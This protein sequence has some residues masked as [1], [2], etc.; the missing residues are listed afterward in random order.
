[1]TTWIEHPEGGR[2][3]GPRGVAR[4]WFEVLTRPQRFFRNGVSPGDQAPGLVF[5]VVVAV[6]YTTVLFAFV[7]A[8]IPELAGG[9]ALSA[10]VG[11]AAVALL[12]A[13]AVLHI[14][15][16]LQ[17]V[18]LIATV[19]ENRGGISETVQVIAYASAPCVVAGIPSPELRIV[20][21]GYG[22]VLMF[23]GLSEVH[24][25]SIP[26][27]AVAGAVPATFLFGYV[28][29]GAT[30]FITIVRTLGVI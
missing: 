14:T 1:M 12:L 20:C 18:F 15:A 28:F 19:W 16:A 6:A 22:A 2:E 3:R 10:F 30:A 11:L 13:P 9:Q 27:A 24:D 7:P 17:T 29:G 25:V 5:A 26:H 23:I 4:A 21:A 8:R